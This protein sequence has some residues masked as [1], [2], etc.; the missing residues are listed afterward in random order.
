[1]VLQFVT[2]AD[3]GMFAQSLIL[4][5]SFEDCGAN[6]GIQV[7]DFGLAA[8]QREFLRARGQL[9]VADSPPLGRRHPWYYKASLGDF[10]SP[11]SDGI[12]WLDADMIVTADPRRAVTTLA[13][14]MRAGGQVIATC[15]DGGN[16]DLGGFCTT[17]SQNGTDTA[18]AMRLF[19]QYRIAPTHSYLNSGFFV[20]LSRP[21]LETWKTMAFEVEQHVLF[22][23]NAFNAAAWRMP[24]TVRLL[25]RRQWN[26]HGTDLA[27]VA[28]GDD[29]RSVSC[30]DVSVTVLHATA[31]DERYA[32]NVQ[33]DVALGA[34]VIPVAMKIFG[35]P[36][37]QSWQRACFSRFVAANAD[38][39]RGCF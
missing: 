34:D 3:S 9:L 38:E 18:P 16:L 27:R 32:R 29:G 33:I 21:W 7:C 13:A 2:G 35:H 31:A 17:W 23:Q 37:L 8:G 26:L 25:D 10:M 14:E 5:Q 28:V 1:M 6:R 4:L 11:G 30:D 15:P 24:E 12:V 22:E 20:A 39:L 19:K 36:V